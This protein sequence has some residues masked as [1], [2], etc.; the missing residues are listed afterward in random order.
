M[1]LMYKIYVKRNVLESLLLSDGPTGNRVFE[2]MHYAVNRLQEMVTFC[3]IS[4]LK[5]FKNYL[6]SLLCLKKH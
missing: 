3:L 2:N 5:L 6:K 4:G 1:C